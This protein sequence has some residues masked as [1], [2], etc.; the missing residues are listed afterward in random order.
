MK[1]SVIIPSHDPTY[2]ADAVRSIWTQDVEADIELLVV[3]NGKAA[4]LVHDGLFQNT[5]DPRAGRP[6][7]WT[8]IVA[9][10]GSLKIG[11]IKNY[12]FM[13]ARGEI[14]VE[15]DHDDLLVPSALRELGEAFLKTGADFVYGNF[16]EF[17]DDGGAAGASV[18]SWD[19]GWGWRER[20]IAFQEGPFLEPKVLSEVIQFESSP[21]SLQKV[22]F[23]PHHPRAWKRDFYRKIGGHNVDLEVCD[24]HE[25]LC[26]A[27]CAGKMYHLD[28]CLYLYRRHAENTINTSQDKILRATWQIYDQWI[29]KMV[30]RWCLER[31]LP[32]VDLALGGRPRSGWIPGFLENLTDGTIGALWADGVLDK[33]ERPL[34]T[35]LEIY[36]A[37]VPGGWLLSRTPSASGKGAFANPLSKSYWNDLTFQYFTDKA[38]ARTIGQNAVRFQPTRLVEYM[39]SEWHSRHQSPYVFFD[40]IALKGDVRG[41]GPVDI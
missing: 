7:R 15:L 17:A 14:L 2:L 29:E 26:R 32:A 34:E 18:N 5:L 6:P 38:F 36:R 27:Y 11:A 40:G 21:M 3:L 24:D 33:Y 37:L 22:Y 23:A 39:P 9:Y 30:L 28:R 19:P 12:G 16:A 20:P 8:E 10:D 31:N 35:M 41:P 1:F 25:I 13:R 4:A